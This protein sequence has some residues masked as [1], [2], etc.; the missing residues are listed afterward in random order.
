MKKITKKMYIV[1][2]SSLL[3]GFVLMIEENIEDDHA[4]LLLTKM[5][6][7]MLPPLH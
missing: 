2:H 4:L 3:L 1:F 6:T 5:K 7:S